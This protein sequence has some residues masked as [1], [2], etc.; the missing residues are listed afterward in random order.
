MKTH[1]L[2]AAVSLVML[3]AMGCNTTPSQDMKNEVKLSPVVGPAPAPTPTVALNPVGVVPVRDPSVKPILNPAGG[4]RD[5]SI[6]INPAGGVKDP[7]VQPVPTP[8]AR[9]GAAPERKGVADDGVRTK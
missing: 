6:K 2:F 7:S 5:P 9:Q 4:I 8:P 1:L 3:A